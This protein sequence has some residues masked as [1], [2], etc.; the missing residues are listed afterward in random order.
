[1]MRSSKRV[2]SLAAA[3]LVAGMVLG[4]LMLPRLLGGTSFLRWR[5]EPPIRVPLPKIV[6]VAF[7]VY[8]RPP[9]VLPADRA[10]RITL[11]GV[12]SPRRAPLR[13]HSP[14]SSWTR[15]CPAWSL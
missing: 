1:M 15:N 8:F 10:R 12:P 6:N 4:C 7:A 2:V 14:A 3:A 13:E 9:G 5:Q 11:C